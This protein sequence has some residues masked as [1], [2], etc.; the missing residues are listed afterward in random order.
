M[1]QELIEDLTAHEQP[2]GDLEPG[3]DFF[4]GATPAQL[5]V[6]EREIGLQLP[7]SLRELLGESNGIFVEFGQHLIWNTD[8]LVMYN[9]PPWVLLVNALDWHDFPDKQRLLF[10]GD[11][12]VDGIRFGFPVT[13][14]NHV[15]EQVFAWYP[16]G[17]EQIH[18]ASS[19]RDYVEGWLTTRLTV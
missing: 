17:K 8:E 10:F 19:L 13:S 18:K 3:P 14:E 4:R 1:W 9:Q 5:D 12:G 6:V 16:I 7:A 11:A 2:I 15:S